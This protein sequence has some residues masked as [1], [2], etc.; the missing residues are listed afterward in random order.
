VNRPL[1]LIFHLYFDSY[2]HRLI[3]IHTDR[4][5]ALI[6]YNSTYF[7]IFVEKNNCTTSINKLFSN[8]NKKEKNMIS[9]DFWLRVCMCV[10]YISNHKQNN[11]SMT[12]LNH[13]THPH[14]KLTNR[15]MSPKCNV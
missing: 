1:R 5:F 10:F 8:I 6:I 9:L 14:C 15:N 2:N 3:N 7:S 12:S 4:T 11:K 13:L